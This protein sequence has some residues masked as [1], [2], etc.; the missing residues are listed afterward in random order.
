MLESAA[1]EE[2]AA[3]LEEPNIARKLAAAARLTARADTIGLEGRDAG[4]RAP[5]SPRV[6]ARPAEWQV[7]GAFDQPARPSTSSPRGRYLLMHSVA[8][9]ELSAV[10]LALLTAADF[11][12][13]P[14]EYYRDW[15]RVAG[16]EVLHA[17][18]V[19]ERLREMGGEFGDAPIHRAL[20]ETA[21]AYP[22]PIE[23]L[24]VVPRIL[25]ARGLD[26]SDRLRTQLR[27][28]GDSQ[29]AN[30]LELIYRDEIGHVATGS[31]WFAWTCRAHGLDPE[32]RFLELWRDFSRERGG[33]PPILDRE[34]RLAAGFSERELEGL[35]A[36]VS[37]GR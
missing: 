36:P 28:A 25:E 17:L 2:I 12:G 6:P 8:N 16:E 31:R 20:W 3:I 13:F 21:S 7:G 37:A 35:S 30:L 5:L 33:R 29:S 1:Y 24:G 14:V 22:D 15:L 27:S 4:A 26:V 23:R 10:E 34:G 11:D 32:D 19:Q 18:E 9:I